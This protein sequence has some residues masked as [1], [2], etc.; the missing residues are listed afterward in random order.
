[1]YVMINL[2][3]KKT[4]LIL[5]RGKLNIILGLERNVFFWSLCHRKFVKL[6]SRFSY[7]YRS[8][9]YNFFIKE[10]VV[11]NQFHLKNRNAP[12]EVMKNMRHFI[13]TLFSISVITISSNFLK[14]I[15]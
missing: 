9:Y 6:I 1:M 8:H 10:I 15:Q 14:K 12:W 11:M 13:F 3:Q 7:S 5:R 4:K 2:L